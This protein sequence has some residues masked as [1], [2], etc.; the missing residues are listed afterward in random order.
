MRPVGLLLLLSALLA[1]GSAAQRT[2]AAEGLVHLTDWPASSEAARA[3]IEREAFE[4]LPFLDTLT[5]GYR[6]GALTTGE[7]RGP[8]FTAALE[9]TPGARGI[10]D[11]REVDAEALPSDV[12]MT[13]LVLRAR[14]YASGR[15]VA[16]AVV[17]V[18]SMQLAAAPD[19]YAFNVDTLTWATVF[20]GASAE[21]ARAL[22]EAG[23]ELRE[24]EIVRVAFASYATEVAEHNRPRWRPRRPARTTVY[25]P[26]FGG[27]IYIGGVIG[28]R[29]R[30]RGL[31]PGR[32]RDMG[33]GSEED[34][35]DRSRPRSGSDDGAEA[36]NAGDAGSEGRGERGAGRTSSEDER[37]DVGGGKRDSGSGEQ[38]TSQRG[39][40]KVPVPKRDD[41]DEDDN[42]DNELLPAA[43]AAAAAVGAV[44]YAGG[45][46]G[47]YGNT[48]Q[49][50]IGL[51]SG[52]IRPGGGVLLQAAVTPSLISSGAGPRHLIAK[53]TGFYN[54]FDAPV[55]PAVGIGVLA[56]DPGEEVD[57]R[58][59]VSLGAVATLGPIV[60]MGG[61][62]V[63]AGGAELG[64]AFNFRY[65]R[66][67]EEPIASGK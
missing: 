30:P 51:T 21:E 58:P 57:L 1:P 28:G 25:E 54:A 3:Y 56:R 61:Y 44:A 6:Y 37:D 36:G 18:D 7:A 45:T 38:A 43:L 26:G 9:W 32:R 65:K 49:A 67:G 22:F 62:D 59:S 42:E 12:E 17:A 16:H 27:N 40:R 2:S 50:P 41:D 15:P 4:V 48:R 24:L 8:R 13:A 60:L 23:F 20:E 66:P 5:L 29:S 33:R 47:Y 19:V 52:F 14:V 31:R 46:V 10:Y 53:L 34:S 39:G 11:G 64:V 55:Q 63:A 35:A